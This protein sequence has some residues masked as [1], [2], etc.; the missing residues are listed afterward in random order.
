MRELLLVVYGDLLLIIP[1]LHPILSIP[2]LLS[3]QALLAS[4]LGI[5]G[6]ID[7]YGIISN[8]TQS[9]SIGTGMRERLGDVIVKDVKGTSPL[10]PRLLKPKVSNESLLR[11]EKLTSTQLP[12]LVRMQ[13]SQGLKVFDLTQYVLLQASRIL[14]SDFWSFEDM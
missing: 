6:G 4:L 3:H 11:I 13:R 8:S 5:V 14:S 7:G 9:F 2:T 10:G 1:I 12:L